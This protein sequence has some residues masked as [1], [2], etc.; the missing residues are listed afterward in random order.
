MK[1]K[2]NERSEFLLRVLADKHPLGISP[3]HQLPYSVGKYHQPIGIGMRNFRRLER[4][5]L[6]METENHLL[7][8]T[9]KGLTVLKEIDD[10]KEN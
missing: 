2:L 5:G 10:E 4:R 7:Y 3:S 9:E 1:Q 6:A 8:I